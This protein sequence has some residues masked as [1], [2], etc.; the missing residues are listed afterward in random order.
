MQKDQQR[1][2]ATR[3]HRASARRRSRKPGPKSCDLA[4]DGDYDV[5]VLP[6]PDDRL[7]AAVAAA[8]DWIN[9]VR[10][11]APCSVFLAAHPAI[12]ARSRRD[13]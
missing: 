2:D 6:W 12:P 5:L 1:A 11:H 9:Y 4:G 3:P 8:D 7:D 13:R 10:Q